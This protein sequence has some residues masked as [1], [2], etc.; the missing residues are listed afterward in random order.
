MKKILVFS[1]LFLVSF[2]LYAA[3]VE[4]IDNETLKELGEQG[5]AI[6]DVRATSEWKDTGIIEGSHLMMFYDEQGKYNLD[7]WLNKLSTAAEKNEP[8]ILICRTG[9]R[10]R[11]LAKYLT[12]VVGYEEVYNVKKG[13]VH[14][15][16]QNNPIV[17]P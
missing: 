7:E 3:E 10:S 16:K 12:K 15:I 2:S 6:I 9:S 5:V 11:Q 1:I 13:I 17:E 4:H 8:V 14:W